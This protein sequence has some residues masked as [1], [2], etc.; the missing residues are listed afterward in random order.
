MPLHGLPVRIVTDEPMRT[1][2]EIKQE[3]QRAIEAYVHQVDGAYCTDWILLAAGVSPLAVDDTQ[4]VFTD[5]G[6]PVHTRL[7][8]IHLMRLYEELPT[9][10][11]DE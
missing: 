8:L 5:S 2:A 6:M 3:L 7:G 1:A 10:A 4:Y 9:P 11:D